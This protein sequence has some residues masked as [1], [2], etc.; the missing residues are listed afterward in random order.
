M[1]DLK[2]ATVE[3]FRAFCQELQA[4]RST[5]THDF[6]IGLEFADVG[7]LPESFLEYPEYVSNCFSISS[8]DGVAHGSMAV[9]GIHR[10][11]QKIRASGKP[12]VVNHAFRSLAC[13][14][15]DA[16]L[17]GEALANESLIC[18]DDIHRVCDATM[19]AGV[20]LE[21]NTGT[22]RMIEDSQEALD[23][24]VYVLRLIEEFGPDM[25]VGSDSHQPT[26]PLTDGIRYVLAEKA[27]SDTRFEVLIERMS[28]LRA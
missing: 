10:F 2:D 27:I 22:I 4:V 13:K 16:A 1:I 25:S 17:A 6:L 28:G 24:F 14:A 23:F 11:G 15:R 26:P 5:V 18:R 21:L 3:G 8:D 19:E 7:R 9:E 20:F 12:G